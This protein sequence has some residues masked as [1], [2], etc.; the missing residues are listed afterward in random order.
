MSSLL[1][2]GTKNDCKKEA[3]TLLLLL[4]GS[5]VLQIECGFMCIARPSLQDGQTTLTHH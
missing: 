4:G 3:C 2:V 5:E 1:L